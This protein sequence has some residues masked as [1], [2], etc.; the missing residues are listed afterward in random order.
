[1]SISLFKDIEELQ[2]KAADARLASVSLI[3]EEIVRFNP[4]YCT[5]TKSVWICDL[6][7]VDQY[8]AFQVVHHA[9]FPNY[10]KKIIYAE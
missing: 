10:F 6:S 7:S 4:K 5:N 1:M 3:L 8:L 9:D 2:Q